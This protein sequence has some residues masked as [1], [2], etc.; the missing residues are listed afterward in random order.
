[1]GHGRL[2]KIT[3]KLRSRCVKLS[4]RKDAIG[5][6]DGCERI[7]GK[8]ESAVPDKFFAQ[9]QRCRLTYLG[10]MLLGIAGHVLEQERSPHVGEQEGE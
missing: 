7:R 9:S 1:V 2:A 4:R 5:C 8:S 10:Q 6:Q 3:C